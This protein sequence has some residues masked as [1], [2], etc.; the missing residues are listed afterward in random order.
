MNFQATEDGKRG[1]AKYRSTTAR[2][3]QH[4]SETNSSSIC[5]LQHIHNFPINIYSFIILIDINVQVNKL[6]R[7]RDFQY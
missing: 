4:R 2:I 7:S 1:G 3:Y 5:I 6:G